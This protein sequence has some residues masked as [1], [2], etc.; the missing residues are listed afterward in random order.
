[1]TDCVM[2]PLGRWRRFVNG[3]STHNRTSVGLKP[4]NCFRVV[5]R[6]SIFWYGIGVQSPFN[7]AYAALMRFISS[8]SPPLSG[9]CFFASAR[10]AAST[11]SI[12]AP[13]TTRRTA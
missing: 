10:Y 11:T 1:M 6:R 12:G 3:A 7:F 2:F 4:S 13:S 8:A 9:W 5:S